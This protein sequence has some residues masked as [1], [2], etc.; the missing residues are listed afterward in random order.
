MSY[1]LFNIKKGR[2]LWIPPTLVGIMIINND[3]DDNSN[4]M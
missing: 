2:N 1:K 3:N 4:D